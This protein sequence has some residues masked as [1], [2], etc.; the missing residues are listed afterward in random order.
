M[1]MLPSR[2]LVLLASSLMAVA[3]A[4]CISATFV[5]TDP[6]A[7]GRRPTQPAIFI[8][9]LP[10]VP[11]Y[12]IGIIEV[13]APAGTTLGPVLDE[14]RRKGGEIGCDFVVDRS[15]YR[16]SYG[17]PGARALLAD[18]TAGGRVILASTTPITSSPP[19]PDRREFICG[20]VSGA[21]ASP[22]AV[23]PPAT[24]ANNPLR[25]R[26]APGAAVR[27]GPSEV[28]P[29]LAAPPADAEIS[30]DGPSREGWRHVTLPDG[31]GGYARDSDLLTDPRP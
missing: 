9:R 3:C 23:A 26:L 11:F 16:V 28:A 13:R 2:P 4:G 29:V 8:D 25:V 1:R 10:P 14:A 17:I 27:T 30:I 24:A 19:A 7:Y 31:R 15:I 5:A 6:Y 21:P 18:G 20:V 22:P 12:S